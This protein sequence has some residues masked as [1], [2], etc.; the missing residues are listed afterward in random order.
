MKTTT[1]SR[2]WDNPK[3]YGNNFDEDEEDDGTNSDDGNAVDDE[4]S[5]EEEVFDTNTAAKRAR[6]CILFT[7]IFETFYSVNL[8]RNDRLS[9]HH[10]ILFIFREE[11]YSF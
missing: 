9:K 3:G 4:I 11:S 8:I 6:K 2:P 5:S 10:S 1:S 7:I